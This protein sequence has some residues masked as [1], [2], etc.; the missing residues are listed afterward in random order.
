MLTGKHIDLRALEPEDLDFL[1][2]VEN[3]EQF[4]E[5][6]GTQT[7]FS[8]EI[9]RKYLHNAH[10]DIYEVKQ[11][12]LVIARKNGDPLGLIDV[13]DFD[14]KNFRA[15]IGI[16]ISASENRGK[17]Y[18]KEAL[19]LLCNYCFD[20]LNLHQVYANVSEENGESRLLFEN[21]G[22]QKIGIKKDWN[23]SKGNFKNIILYQLL[24][25]VH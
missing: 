14:P 25:H 2:A 10:R 13:F 16:L 5:I 4:W 21:Q 17:G 23:Y 7:P 24:A 12:R 18:G 20:H 15:G 8:K 19:Q 9:L 1:F 22:F 11:L 3:D 6:S